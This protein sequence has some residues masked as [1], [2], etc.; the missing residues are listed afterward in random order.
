MGNFLL[1]RLISQ[2]VKD[3]SILRSG[4]EFISKLTPNQELYNNLENKLSTI[5]N[6]E[7]DLLWLWKDFSDETSSYLAWFIFKE[8]SSV[9]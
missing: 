7:E 3:I 6:N 5:K 9:P 1:K 4:T 2:P 8:I